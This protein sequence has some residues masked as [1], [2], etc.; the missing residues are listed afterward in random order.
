MVRKHYENLKSFA[1][2]SKRVWYVLKKPAKKEFWSITKISAVGILILGV[3]G[4]LISIIMGAFV[5]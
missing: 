4:F 2:K 1:I 5:K 3:L